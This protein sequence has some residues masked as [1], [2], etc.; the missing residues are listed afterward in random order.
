M[1]DESK[2]NWLFVLVDRWLPSFK[3]SFGIPRVIRFGVSLVP[4]DIVFPD[5][6]SLG[7]FFFDLMGLVQVGACLEVG[8][9]PGTRPWLRGYLGARGR[10]VLS[11]DRLQQV[12]RDPKDGALFWRET[13]L[14]LIYKGR[15]ALKLWRVSRF[16]GYPGALDPVVDA[17]CYLGTEQNVE[18]PVPPYSK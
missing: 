14:V 17:E 8:D 5:V 1:Q 7:G 9:V 13:R 4:G 11:F 12:V 6:Q 3:I 18:P 15:P 10:W 16:L 2:Q